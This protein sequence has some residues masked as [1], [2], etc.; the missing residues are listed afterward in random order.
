MEAIGQSDAFL[1]F[2]EQLSRVA[3]IDRP[4]LIIGERGTGKELAAARLHYLSTRWQGPLVT[5]NCAALAGSLL[6]SELFGHE[7]GAFTGAT[8]RS[9]GR[10]ENADSG[11]LFLDE[12][13]NLPLQAQEKILRVVEYGTFDR[14]GGSR[15]VEVNV[16]IVGATNV[17]LPARARA[18]AFK[19]DLLDRLSFEVLTV[20]PLRVREGDVELLARHFATRMAVSLGLDEQPRFSPQAM[21]AL[22]RHH[23][24]GNVRELKNVVERSVYRAEHAAMTEV[25]FDPFLSPYRPAPPL[26][27]DAPV[28]GK[29]PEKGGGHP[30]L[31]TPLAKA[32]QD[33]EDE[34]LRAALERSHFNQKQAAAILGMSYHQFRR[35]YRKRN[36]DF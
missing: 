12:I 33:L 20:P 4:V 15:P 25:I 36:P 6:D 28:T 1:Q 11:T 29:K 32:V 13:A 2:Q 21:S 26:I 9:K 30:S 14:V 31:D 34:Y 22:T 7:A 24:P 23:W 17:D 27:P 18:G 5:L 8:S 19:E 16:R 35:L 10:F 3:R